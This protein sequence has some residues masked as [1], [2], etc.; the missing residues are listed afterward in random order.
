MKKIQLTDGE[1]K[2]LKKLNELGQKINAAE[3]AT[4]LNEKKERII[5][6]LNSLSE[7]GLIQLEIIEIESY[8]L[9]NEGENYFQN[10]LPEIR[11]FHAIQQL[12]EK[13]SIEEAVQKSGL[14]PQERGIAI[15][16]A[17]K[18]GWIEILKEI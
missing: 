2:V 16:W 13:C 15:S 4:K 7:R 9:T 6:I 10:G 11:L 1:R 5:S 8:S 17:R 18:S 3:L 14:T 12:G